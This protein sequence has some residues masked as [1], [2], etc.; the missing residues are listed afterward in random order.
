MKQSESL[1]V[2]CLIK[3]LW[4]V[5]GQVLVVKNTHLFVGRLILYGCYGHLSTVH[6]L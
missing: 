4:S 1:N 3:L 5:C 6:E 2:S